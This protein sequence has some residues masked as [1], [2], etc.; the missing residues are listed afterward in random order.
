MGDFS[1]GSVWNDL[2]GLGSTY[3][4]GQTETRNTTPDPS[5]V[6]PPQ[7]TAV[8][9]SGASMTAQANPAEMMVNSMP[10]WAWG[11]IGFAVLVLLVLLI[12]II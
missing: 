9:S 8:D 6:T 3:L 7:T 10:L 5:A 11:L 4:E 12:K 2:V 1:L